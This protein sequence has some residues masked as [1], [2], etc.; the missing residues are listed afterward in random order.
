MHLKKSKIQYFFKLQA[1][2][3]CVRVKKSC[4]AN[5][6]KQTLLTKSIAFQS[7]ANLVG[8]H[9]KEDGIPKTASG[10]EVLVQ[11]CWNLHKVTTIQLRKTCR[12]DFW[13]LDY[14]YHSE[15]QKSANTTTVPNGIDQPIF[16]YP[17]QKLI[18]NM[19]W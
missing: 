3:G 13:K 6:K 5:M 10:N 14:F 8:F 7:F 2:G 17:S 1:K 11:F 19:M 4:W 9:I 18:T 12:M 15:S 16:K